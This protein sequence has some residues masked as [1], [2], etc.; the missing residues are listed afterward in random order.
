MPDDTPPQSAPLE[1][2]EIAA[3][4]IGK[5]I[6]ENTPQGWV[7]AYITARVGADPGFAFISNVHRKHQANFLREVAKDL[8]TRSP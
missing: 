7:F 8:D 6:A 2:A 3:Q 5:F 4:R 1:S